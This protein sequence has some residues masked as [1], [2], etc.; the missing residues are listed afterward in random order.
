MASSLDVGKKKIL[1][2][3][4]EGLSL[5]RRFISIVSL[6]SYE[7]SEISYFLVEFSIS[8]EN[9]SINFPNWQL[10]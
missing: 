2:D 4:C 6:F 5:T 7:F 9:W 3:R 8:V 10:N 1:V